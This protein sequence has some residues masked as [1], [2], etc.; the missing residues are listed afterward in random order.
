LDLEDIKKNSTN[1]SFIHHPGPVKNDWKEDFRTAVKSFQ[2][3]S[4]HLD[5][6]VDN[7]LV[8]K[9]Y[10][11]FIPLELVHRIK[12]AGPNSALWKQFIPDPKELN[13]ER[14][15]L[16]PIGDKIQQETG[17]IIHRYS[18]RLLFLPTELCPV[19]C[20]YCF[21]KNEL[22][23]NLLI[24]SRMFQKSLKYIQEHT[25]VNE[26]IF[27]GGD[28]LILDNKI[29]SQYLSKLIQIEHIQFIRFH[30]RTPIII[31]SRITRD[32]TQLLASMR[33]KIIMMVHLNHE[34]E[35]TPENE[36]ALKK[37]KDSGVEVFSQT[38]LLKGVN[39]S[40]TELKNLFLRLSQ[41]GVI[42]YYLHHPDQV[43]GGM[44]FYLPISEGR[45]IYQSLRDEL[46]GWM[47]PQY[48]LDSADGQG[49]VPLYNPES[50]E[51]QGEIIDKNG[52]IRHHF[53][54]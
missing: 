3:L 41:L 34:D 42:P 25:E 28:P 52:N 8:V 29:L 15:F 33:K 35:L 14:G 23:D 54:Q 50:Y 22:A 5:I 19:N 39:D 47:I 6:C 26:V 44:H 38:V 30:T 45:K 16:D 49:K 17:Q 4:K 48:I 43:R 40:T 46:S 11:V 10:P 2:E 7:D 32:F 1:N 18:S 24:E 27:S 9:K 36:N 13:N 51:F 20:R 53:E 21:R 31:P 12:E 37:L